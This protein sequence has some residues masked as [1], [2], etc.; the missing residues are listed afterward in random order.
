MLTS[1]LLCIKQNTIIN[2][3]KSYT[4][5]WVNPYMNYKEDTVFNIIR[6]S[7]ARFTRGFLMAREDVPNEPVEPNFLLNTSQ[8]V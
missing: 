4:N 1:I 5:R 6:K 8:T 3:I 7:N 2:E